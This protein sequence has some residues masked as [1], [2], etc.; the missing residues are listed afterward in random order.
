MTPVKRADFPVVLQSIGQVQAYNTV[1]VRARVDGQIMKIGFDEGQMVKQGDLLAQIDARPFQAALEQ[2]AAK[3]AQDEAN[4]ANAKLDLARFATL[5]KQDFATKQ[6]LDTQNAMVLQLTA[7]I[8]ADTAAVD[9]AKTQLDYT[10]IRAP[11]SGRAG[12]RLIDEGNLVNAGQQT[13]IVSIAQLQ[14]ITVVFAEPQGFVPRI[15]E[16]LAA[17]APP[18]TVMDAEGHKLATGRLSISDN[19]V[20]AATGT[21]R[22]KAEFDNKDNALWPGLAVTTGLQLGVE[23]DVLIV[24]TEVVQHGQN[25]LFV[26]IVDDQNRAQL[27]QVKI[28]HEDTA[29]AVISEGLKEGDRVVTSGQFLP[30]A[31]IDR[32]DRHGQR[33]LSPM[34]KGLSAPFINRPI[35]TTL[36]MV[37]VLLVG[38]VAFPSLPVAPLPQVDFP[39]IA[40]SASLPGASPDTMASSVAQPLERQIAQIPGVSQ[41]TSTSSLGATAITVQFDLNRNID[42]AANDIQAAINAAS[43]Q[44]PKDLPSPPTYRKVNPSDTPILILSVQS[45]VAPIIDVDDAAE[46][47]LAQHLSQISGVSLVRV[48]GQQ[49]PAIRIQIDPAK[50]VQ[51]GM[52]LED[53][54]TQIAIATANSPKGALIGPKQTFTVQANDQL[55]LAKDWNDVIV[56]YRNGAPVRVRDIGRAIAG[57]QDATQAAWSNGKR[58]VFLVVFKIPGAN[59]INT[60]EAIKSTLTTLQASIPP[61]INVSILSDRTMTIRA[62]VRDVEF[63]LALT[64]ALVVM[65]IF[66]FLRNL[67]ATII[68]SVTVPL[69]L[70][71]S[72]A[73]MWVAG[74][75]LDNLSLMAFTI[76][77]GFVVDDAIV[78][79]EN[80]TRHIEEGE[81]PFQAA[82]KG[83]AE[84]GFTIISISVSLVAVL[85][86]LLMMSGIIGR[87]FREFA[88]TI[89]MTIVV[90][91]FVSL[92]LTPMMASRFLKSRDEEKHGR[93]YKL[94]EKGFVAMANGYA[95]GVDFVLRHRFA[96]LLTFIATVIA[97]GYLFV[98]IPKG[99]FPQQDTGILFGT[100]EAGQDV[101][102]HD[103]Y[104]LQ[105]QVGKII[106]DDPAVQSMA[107]GL[108][109]GVG[110]AAQ[111]NGRMF[112]QLKPQE[113]REANAFQV[114][115]RLR[116]KLAQVPGMRVYLQAAQDVTV[117]AR[118]ARDFSSSTRCRTPISTSSTP[119]PPRSS[120][121]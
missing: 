90:S 97:T 76:A 111:N 34:Y 48:G 55:T 69:A 51:K 65:V 108:G 26:F 80:I 37:A 74:Y 100:T 112:I 38:L 77:V 79:L 59:V 121:S 98:I 99:F 68:P 19:Q 57:P 20:D 56:A 116:P 35:A 23:K 102:F 71:G 104:R 5:A 28:A 85:I 61:T 75:S 31:R 11:I 60:V 103:M 22:L 32:F 62:S 42:A 50:L 43:G 105:Q 81:K 7:S 27:R 46:N 13:G 88:V 54:R 18:V 109:V 53:V 110:N 16:E 120:T 14:P 119:G 10:T 4:L 67:W 93:L 21:I 73:L 115:A 8:A 118:F 66:V 117:G 82:L 2:A 52:Q 86:P 47:I 89:A 95:R 36:I 49:T 92:T 33:N 24:P 91:A 58:S 101:S 83:S 15:N 84:I 25:G 30:A 72:C 41:M 17:G 107:M 114:I 96:T 1:L 45:D 44:L 78:M 63:T 29:T 12:F 64:I 70:L 40:V 6:Q 9:A 39:T 94:S 87:L 113:D 106:Q 3:K